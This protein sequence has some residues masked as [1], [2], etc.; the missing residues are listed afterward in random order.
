MTLSDNVFYV[1]THMSQLD[2]KVIKEIADERKKKRKESNAVPMTIV[3]NFLT[4][5]DPVDLMTAWEVSENSIVKLHRRFH[6]NE[7]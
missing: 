5:H 7:S 6:K 3:H 4:V 1:V 2:L